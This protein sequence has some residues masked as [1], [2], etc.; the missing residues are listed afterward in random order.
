MSRDADLRKLPRVDRVAAD[1]QLDG[2]R[3][4]LGKDA[5]TRLARR[6]IAESRQSVKDGA[7]AP[8]ASEVAAN[9][10]ALAQS[11]L[12]AR[13]VRVINATGVVLHTNLGR[14]PLAR[15]VADALHASAQRYTSIELD[16][17]TGRRGARGAFIESSLAHLTGAEAALVVNNNAAAVLLMLTAVAGF[18]EK[19]EARG[20]IVSR[21]ELIEIGGGF[22]VPDVLARSGARLIEVGT[23]NRTR[24]SDYARA[25]DDAGDVAAILRVHQGNFRQSG[26]VERPS[27]AELSTL[28]RARGVA[29]LKDLGGGAFVD[30]APA[31]LTGEPLVRASIAG[32]ADVVCFSTDKAL[33]GP[34]GGAL[35]GRADLIERARRDPLAR[36]LRL[37]RLPLVALEATLALYLEGK[38][39]RVPALAAL[40]RPLASVHAR[41]SEWSEALRAKGVRAGVVDL[42]AVAGGG[43]YADERVASAGIA[44]DPVAPMTAD[45]LADRLRQNEPPILAR[46]HEERVLLDARTVL[47]DE[48]ALVIAGVFGALLEHRTG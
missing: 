34:Q 27:L 1:A 37:G 40:R 44:L 43:A 22:R 31:G 47:A 16:L 45:A 41:A 17:T 38:E 10:L 15:E 29:L 6:A 25:L 11:T 48:D 12:A 24:A 32:G 8:T 26:F 7:A 5:V 35:V 28:A 3:R 9:V 18:S 2:V 39:D 30:L 21:S 46:I 42:E 14:A 20:V 13:S 23:T 19:A 36:A 4:R 33:G